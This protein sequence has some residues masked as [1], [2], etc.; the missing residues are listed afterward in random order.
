MLESFEVKFLPQ[1]APEQQKIDASL[2]NLRRDRQIPNV[3][4]FKPG[5]ARDKDGRQHKKNKPRHRAEQRR[6]G[7]T[8][9][10]KD[11]GGGK[12]N[13]R[14]HEVERDNSHVITAENDHV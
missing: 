12:D 7:V 14:G 2:K 3:F 11:T 10:L 4:D 8:K 9:P 5:R 1:L 13:S 6:P